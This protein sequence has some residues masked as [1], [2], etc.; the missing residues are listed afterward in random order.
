[1]TDE[2]LQV[3]CAQMIRDMAG[4]DVFR[5]EI[6]ETPLA[7]FPPYYIDNRE[8]DVVFYMTRPLLGL[9]QSDSYEGILDFTDI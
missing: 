8:G 1:M 7:G 9:Y 3:F 4:Y 6:I 5:I 2:Q